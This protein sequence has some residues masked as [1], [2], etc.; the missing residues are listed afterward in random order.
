[1]PLT[2][3][4]NYKISKVEKTNTKEQ[5]E[6]ASQVFLKQI[7]SFSPRPT[8]MNSFKMAIMDR[9]K[10][11]KPE[12]SIVRKSPEIKTEE[13]NFPE[14]IFR[15]KSKEKS[16]DKGK[17]TNRTRQPFKVYKNLAEEQKSEHKIP[18]Q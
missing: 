17:D 6:L 16:S 14:D 2:D 12:G 1:M 7:E 11:D 15:S 13:K 9:R 5:E 8:E 18:D 4:K 3:T 10:S